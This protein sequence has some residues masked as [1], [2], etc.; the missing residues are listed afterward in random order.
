MQPGSRGCGRDPVS[1]SPLWLLRAL[2]VAF[3][4]A[5]LEGLFLG[6]AFV[7]LVAAGGFAALAGDLVLS[8]AVAHGTLAERY[9]ASIPEKKGTAQCLMRLCTGR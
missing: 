2:A 7:G 8:T 3:G 4:R 5:R 1:T 6:G 9:I